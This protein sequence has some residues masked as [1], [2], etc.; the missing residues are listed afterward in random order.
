VDLLATPADEKAGIPVSCL[1]GEG[2]DHLVEAV[3]TKACGVRSSE[4]PALAAI[5]A[6]HQSCL[7]RAREALAQAAA[8]L[9]ENAAPELIAVPLREALNA[10]GEVAGAADIEEI[11]GQI[12]STFCIGK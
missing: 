6:R 7:E 8:S 9:R 3:V 4:S 10:V 5:N 2:I 11:L 12:F 1:T